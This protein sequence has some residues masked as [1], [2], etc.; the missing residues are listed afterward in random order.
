MANKQKMLNTT[1]HYGIINQNNSDIPL[2]TYSEKP[3]TPTTPNTGEDGCKPSETLTDFRWRCKRV[4][5]P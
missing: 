2:Y 3:E 4:Q 5:S 1:Y